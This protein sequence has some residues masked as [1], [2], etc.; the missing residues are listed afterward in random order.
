MPKHK[1]LKSVAHNTG[2]S[3]T[4]LMNYASY[5]YVMGHILRLAR[6]T[7]LDTLE[8]NLASGEGR[9]IKLLADP[10]SEIP[11]HASGR[12]WNLVQQHGA[13]RSYVHS[14]TLVLRYNINVERPVRTYPQLTESP[15]TCDVRITDDRGKNYDAHFEGWWYPERPD[16]NV[17]RLKQRWWKFWIR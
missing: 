5:D 17:G 11:A 1:A 12:F 7:G 10:I 15:Y 8:I 13:D 6:S 4:S 3:F 2:H 16:T 9:P 14:A